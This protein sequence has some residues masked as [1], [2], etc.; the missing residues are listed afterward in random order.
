MTIISVKALER[1]ATAP[2]QLQPSQLWLA[3]KGQ[4]EGNRKRKW[5]HMAMMGQALFHNLLMA[6]SKSFPLH[7][8]VHPSDATLSRCLA[9]P[10]KHKAQP[11][12]YGFEA[13]KHSET[14]SIQLS[15]TSNISLKRQ[16]ETNINRISTFM[17]PHGEAAFNI[18]AIGIALWPLD[19]FNHGPESQHSIRPL[20]QFRYIYPELS[21]CMILTIPTQTRNT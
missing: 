2:E 16:M 15:W 1:R 7:F 6:L 14:Q 12:V 9:A 21:F 11:P 8:A 5:G 19:L 3:K 18:R 10:P 20:S 4:E 13:S 17:I